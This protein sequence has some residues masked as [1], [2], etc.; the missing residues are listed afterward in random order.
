[1][2][3]RRPTREAYVGIE[4]KIAT[5]GKGSTS[6]AGE[7]RRREGLGLHPLVD[8]AGYGLVRKSLPRY[9]DL[10]DGRLLLANGLPMLEETL[11][12]TTGSM[13]RNVELAFRVL[14]TTYR[15]LTEGTHPVLGRYDPQL[16]SAIFG[17]VE[18]HT[19]LHR[20]QAE[21]DDKI[22]EQL[23]FMVPER[24][25]GDVP[26]DPD[27][28][29][30]GAA[31]LTDA[32]I[33]RYGLSSYHTTVTDAPGRGRID[34]KN[35]VRVFGETVFDKVRD[36]GF[37][38]TEGDLPTT[39]EIVAELLKH[40]HAFVIQVGNARETARFWSDIYGVER[41][42][43]VD[44]TQLLPFVKAAIIGLTEGVLDLQS[45]TAYLESVGCS[46]TEARDITRAVA[47]IPIGA[48]AA[49]PNFAKIPLKGSVF[50]K[51]QDLW[52]IADVDGGSD[53][54]VPTD[55]EGDSVW[56]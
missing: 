10:P 14:P 38:I 52:P 49:L 35:L 29:L 36:N 24:A 43:V 8:P 27:Y 21:S 25:G 15:L 32:F 20:S 6:Y 44:S 18:D 30:F 42:V 50:A 34:P 56:L 28:G 48:Q 12:D 9:V 1:M 31:Y 47:G 40:A 7:Q 54:D 4:K 33:N 45:I 16:I 17:D 3:D 51:K 13:G 46:K 39:K 37:Q 22:A 55:G 19:I 5:E 41:V 2:G 26:E 53:V 23:T 11:L